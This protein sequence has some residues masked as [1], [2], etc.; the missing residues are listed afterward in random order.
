MTGVPTSPNIG[1]VE[2]AGSG[3]DIKITYGLTGDSIGSVFSAIG[4]SIH[5]INTTT[6]P[7]DFHFFQYTNLDLTGPAGDGDAMHFRNASTVEQVG[8]SNFKGAVSVVTPA[9]S[10]R[11]GGLYPD[12][13]ASLNDGA[14]TTLSDLP[15]IGFPYILGDVDWGYQ[16]DTTLL[17]GVDFV[18]SSDLHQQDLTPGTGASGDM[19]DDGTYTQLDIDLFALALRNRDA[20]YNWLRP[21]GLCLC[22]EPE[23]R[24]DMNNDGRFDLDDVPYFTA[25]ISQFGSG[26]LDFASLS[27]IRDGLVPEPTSGLLVVSA[28]PLLGLRRRRKK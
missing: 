27:K 21:N 1:L 28:F 23:E 2:Y 12:I 7:I 17:P 6:S 4:E 13:L 10:H 19:S 24:G 22:L 18:I 14:P 3:L 11:Q 15:T 26:S 8:D 16:W 9:P 20:Y 5:V 25:A